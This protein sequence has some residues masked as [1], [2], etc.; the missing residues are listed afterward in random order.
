M[1]GKV[2]SSLVGRIEMWVDGVR[3]NNYAVLESSGTFTIN[4][5]GRVP[6]Q[7]TN[8]RPRMDTLQK[9]KRYRCYQV[10]HLHTK[11]AAF[12]YPKRRFFH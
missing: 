12:A 8:L 9:N 5:A 1:T 7:I 4:M 3:K 6:S 10:D 2:N 11:K